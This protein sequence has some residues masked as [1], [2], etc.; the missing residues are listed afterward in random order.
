MSGRQHSQLATHH[1]ECLP[2]A[3]L[4]VVFAFV[5]SSLSVCLSFK[6]HRNNSLDNPMVQ[7]V[8]AARSKNPHPSLRVP[9]PDARPSHPI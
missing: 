4:H 8:H 7:W 3:C 1:L 9:R 6:E 5:S 2:A